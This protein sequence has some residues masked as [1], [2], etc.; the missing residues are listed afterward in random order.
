M[1]KVKECLPIALVFSFFS[2]SAQVAFTPGNIVVYR[3]GTGAATLTNAATAVFLDEY[4]S[5]GTLVQSIAMPVAVSGSNKILTAAGTGSSEGLLNL[6]IDG[7]YVV[8]TGYNIAVGT[9]GVGG[10][11]STTRPRTVGLV[12]YNAV[13]NTSTAFTD[14]S[15]GGPVRSAISINGTDVWACGGGATGGTGGVRY[16][17][18]GATTSTQLHSTGPTNLRA[19]S[20][21]AGQLY[22]SGNSGSPRIGSVGTGCPTTSGQTVTGLPGFPIN[23]SPG[24]FVL[25]DL[26][27]AVSG[28][29]VLYVAD[30]VNGLEKY[31][32]V[33][34]N[35]VANGIIGNSADDYRALGATVSGGTVTLYATRRGANSSTIEGGEL[36]KFTDPFGYNG[37]F[38]GTPTVIA[39]AVTDRTAFRGVSAVPV[40]VVL[41][42]SLVSFTADKMNNDVQLNW[43]ASDARNFSHF[44]VERSMDGLSF[45]Y[46]G[47][48]NLRATTL[49]TLKYDFKDAGILHS[50]APGQLLYY[51]LKMID[52]DGH[53]QYSK[54]VKVDTEFKPG[55]ISAYPDPFINEIFVRITALKE[56][57]VNLLMAD[58]KGNTVSLIQKTLQPGE[59]KLTLHPPIHLPKGV[60]LLRVY[61]NNINTTLKLVK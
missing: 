40:Q 10:S 1:R 14:L 60:Y 39:T 48:G 24:Q 19:I 44:E 55:T 35:W 26:N 28:P 53:I 41:P 7:Q 29:D 59:N 17:A 34:G 31:S 30:D 52:T 2:A 13:I 37:T 16:A 36:V 49:G 27:A 46:I 45:S 18:V 54:M 12:G 11:G 15:S 21:A 58:A 25:L 50:L 22:V 56:E 51:R 42:I 6:S 32:F 47:Q 38:V 61:G 4:T 3:V 8:C 57:R 5:S 23:G 33:S 9:S 43:A 20:V